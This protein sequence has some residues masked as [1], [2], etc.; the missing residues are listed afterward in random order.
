MI[1]KFLHTRGLTLKA[2]AL[3]ADHVDA[4]SR[5]KLPGFDL[6]DEEAGIKVFDW[7]VPNTRKDFDDVLVAYEAFADRPLGSFTRPD[8]EAIA[9][10]ASTRGRKFF[11]PISR[12]WNWWTPAVKLVA[13]ASKV[14]GAPV[15]Y[16]KDR[17]LLEHKGFRMEVTPNGC[18]S[19]FRGRIRASDGRAEDVGRD[20]ISVGAWFTKEPLAAALIAVGAPAPVLWACN[21]LL[22]E[23]AKEAHPPISMRSLD[24]EAERAIGRPRKGPKARKPADVL[25]A[26]AQ[27]REAMDGA[28][29]EGLLDVYRALVPYALT[30]REFKEAIGNPFCHPGTSVTE[31]TRERVE[32]VMGTIEKGVAA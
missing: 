15:E 2:K 14:S 19:N 25:G 18:W 10:C 13:V 1:Q 5:V 12:R 31:A 8:K 28:Q 11:G 3:F 26:L 30:S 9:A 29:G 22:R 20:Y 21:S 6:F 16:L 7:C 17:V 4:P 32:E 23:V 24:M 27:A